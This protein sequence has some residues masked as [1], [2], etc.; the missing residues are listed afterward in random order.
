MSARSVIWRTRPKK[1]AD[2][3][4]RPLRAAEPRSLQV[5]LLG[6]L[7][8]FL[9]TLDCGPKR[10]TGLRGRR[11][12]AGSGLYSELAVLGIREGSSPGLIGRIGRKAARLPSFAV[13]RNELAEDGVPL[14][15]KVVH[16]VATQ[17]GQ[18]ML[19]TRR[20]DLERY[21]AG[22]MPAGEEWKDKRVGCA[23]DG[24]RIRTRVV[25]RKQKGRGKA[26]KRRR[27]MR[28]EWREPK[29]LI[30]FEMNDKGRMQAGTR[31]WI[32]ATF[33]GPDACLELLAMHLHR[34]G[35][36]R[37]EAVAFLADGAPWIWDRL[38][39][40]EQRVGLEPERVAKVLD[41]CHAVHPM[42]LALKG[43][44]LTEAERA[45]RYRALRRR[46]RA[47]RP[48]EVTAELS[49]WAEA[50]GISQTSETWTSIR[51]LENHA[52]K[53]RLQSCTFRRRGMPLGSGAVESAIRRL[54]NLRLK[55]N[56]LMWYAENAEGMLAMRAAAL[57]G[58]WRESL[59]QVREAMMRDRKWE[60]EWQSPDMLEELKAKV[61]IQPPKPQIHANQGKEEMAA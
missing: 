21:R 46:L 6:G 29:V 8:L 39:W 20:R 22:E 49:V 36:A 42:S 31:P 43:L 53:G 24:G 9:T 12:R 37:A 60:W 44:N 45:K 2:Q 41:C 34:L 16:G 54:V 25:V 5:R 55:G 13:A 51:D 26:K 50:A 19:T 23:I 61:E 47:G 56:G 7:V 52:A 4:A 30:I 28:V 58:R 32:D 14:D 1:A 11:G 27:K 38:E 17:L 59:E 10:G 35:A 3:A 40:V 57:T 15:I 48:C 33:R 18:E